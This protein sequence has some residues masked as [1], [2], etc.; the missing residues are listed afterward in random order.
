MRVRVFSNMK[1]EQILHRASCEIICK[2]DVKRESFPIWPLVD[3][4]HCSL[5]PL[6]SVLVRAHLRDCRYLTISFPFDLPPASLSPETDVEV[7]EGHVG[8]GRRTGHMKW[9]EREDV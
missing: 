4:P 7:G 6:L 1:S 5:W 8:D 3:L 9:N 2:L